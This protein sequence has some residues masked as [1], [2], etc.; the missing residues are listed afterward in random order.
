VRGTFFLNKQIALFLQHL[1][2]DKG[3]SVHTLSSYGRDLA[4]FESISNTQLFSRT[5]K[6]VQAFLKVLKTKGLK[7]TSIARKVSALKQFYQFYLREGEI[8]ENPTLFIESPVQTKRLPKALDPAAIEALLEVTNTGIP[9][10]G[11]LKEALRARDQAMIYLLYAT[12]VRVSELVGIELSK[13]DVEAGLI[14]VLGKRSKERMIPFARIAGAKI[15]HYLTVGRP[16]LK[17]KSE[18]LFLGE[19]GVPLTRQAFWK[20]LK[21]LASLAGIR[22]SLHPHMLRHTFATDL[23]RSG[24]NLRTLQ[25]LLGHAD[26]QTTEI[27]THVAPEKLKEVVE[28]FHPRGGTA[29]N[30]IRQK[31][32]K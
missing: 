30:R 16:M 19:R 27:Y 10:E 4:Q 3:A 11:A 26:L 9:Y 21:K 31:S 24:M 25:M 1:K 29:S 2:I 5:E 14:R 20:T 32:S 22:A 15:H 6:D 12:G 17:P 7:S 23:L 18:H 28:K 8:S 13:C